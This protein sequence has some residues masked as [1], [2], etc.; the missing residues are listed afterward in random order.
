MIK[1][2]RANTI[3]VRKLSQ[4]K[5]KILLLSSENEDGSKRILLL[6]SVFDITKCKINSCLEYQ[7]TAL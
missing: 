3:L 6:F 2:G 7:Y 1:I 5:L 4:S